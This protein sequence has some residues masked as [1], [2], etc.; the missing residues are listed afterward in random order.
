MSHILN[1]FF[2]KPFGT[3]TFYRGWGG[4][5]SDADLPAISK[6]V[7]SMNVKFCRVI[8]TPLKVSEMFKFKQLLKSEVFW[9]KIARFQ[10]KMPIIQIATK[11]TIFKINFLSK[12]YRLFQKYSFC[13]GRKY[14]F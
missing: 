5:G 4:G 2:T 9:G 13:L 6:T 10:P 3:H 1:P 7:V 14:R 12:Y 8:E 11:F